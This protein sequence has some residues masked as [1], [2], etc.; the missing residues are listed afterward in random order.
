MGS[1]GELWLVYKASS[2]KKT[3]LTLD[4]TGYFQ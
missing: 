4:L 1:A 2:G 3:H